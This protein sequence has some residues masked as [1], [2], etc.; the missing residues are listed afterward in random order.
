M[1]VFT[2]ISLRKVDKENFGK[3]VGMK[4]V[5]GGEEFVASNVYSLAQAW[6]FYEE[7][8]PFAIYKD[9]EIIGFMMLEWYEKGRE[10]GIW[11]FMIAEEQQGKGY[12][13]EAMK[14]AIEMIKAEDKFD[15]ISLSYVPG[16]EAGQ[17]VYEKLGF[18]ATGEIDDGEIIMKLDL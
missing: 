9:E 15:Y 6:L 4:L 5:N 12:G 7:A 13:T 8:R 1:G 16:N 17:H 18:K 14:V 11:R 10:A 2:M 3:V